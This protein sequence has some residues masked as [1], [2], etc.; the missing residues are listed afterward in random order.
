MARS[1]ALERGAV[2]VAREGVSP[3]WRPRTIA[4]A[5]IGLPPSG[6]HS[7]SVLQTA[8]QAGSFSVQVRLVPTN[9]HSASQPGDSA[10]S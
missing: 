1:R 8:W 6:L 3:Y 5:L 2:G 9:R 7:G 4:Q 10:M